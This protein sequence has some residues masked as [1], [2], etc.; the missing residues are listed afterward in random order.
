M[1]WVRCIEFATSIEEAANNLL[2]DP[3]TRSQSIL[4]VTSH[5]PSGKTTLITNLRRYYNTTSPSVRFFDDVTFDDV[6]D[7][8]ASVQWIGVTH[9]AAYTADLKHI[10]QTTNSFACFYVPSLSCGK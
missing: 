1:V 6:K 8:P 2:Q 7:L 3:A 5:K 10:M 9:D 4:I